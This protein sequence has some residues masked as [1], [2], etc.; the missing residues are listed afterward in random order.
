VFINLWDATRGGVG[1]DV[2]KTINS[3]MINMEFTDLKNCVSSKQGA[4]KFLGY[5][6]TVF[7]YV[8]KPVCENRFFCSLCQSVRLELLGF[9][10]PYAILTIVAVVTE[11]SN[12]YC[13]VVTLAAWLLWCGHISCLVTVVWSH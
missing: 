8:P 10:H 3:L 1:H 13:G 4:W 2:F 5:M 9:V 6:T 7:G 12:G 11:V